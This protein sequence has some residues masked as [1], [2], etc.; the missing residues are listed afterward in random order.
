MRSIAKWFVVALSA[1]AKADD[2]PPGKIVLV[3]IAIEKLDLSF[4]LQR[5]IVVNRDFRC[6]EYVCPL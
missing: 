6:H 5:A 2:S 4:D 3:P 1:A